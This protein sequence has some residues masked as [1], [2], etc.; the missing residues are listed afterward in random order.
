MM[1]AVKAR[2][3]HAQKFNQNAA[4]PTRCNPCYIVL[5]LD[6]EAVAIPMKNPWSRLGQMRELD[7]TDNT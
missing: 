7:T 4:L 2:S 1:K 3:E 6:A 5:M